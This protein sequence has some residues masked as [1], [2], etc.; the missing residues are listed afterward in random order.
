MF[1]FQ[2]TAHA[3]IVFEPS[4][5]DFGTISEIDGSVSHTFTG[6]NRGDKPVVIIEVITSCG[7]TVPQFSKQPIRPGEKTSIK[8]TYNPENRPGVFSKDLGVYSSEKIKIATLT[9]KGAVTPRPKSIEE[10]Y[11]I[12][13]GGGIRISSSTCAFSYIR[14]GQHVQSAIGYINT[15]DSAQH[16]SLQSREESGLLQMHYA[17]TIAPGEEGEINFSYLNPED[18]TRYGTI[19]DLLDIMV[20]GRT[21]GT[22]IAVYGTGIDRPTNT[23]SQAPKAQLS[24]NIIKFGTVKHGSPVRQ[25]TFSIKN[26]GRSELI[27]RAVETNGK[28]SAS[29]TSGERIAPGSSCE[30]VVTLNA[31]EQDYGVMTD[32]V[33]ITTNDPARPVRRIRVTAIIED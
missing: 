3:Q 17:Q 26:E 13:V 32:V 10:I 5:H 20:G 28:I 30:T 19:S 9:V 6:I 22:I 12:E 11:P 8:I 4:V 14:A 15:S 21:T 1:A 27:I 16:I 29:L 2:A 31:R 33:I 7:C 23:G 24:E 25:H 18:D